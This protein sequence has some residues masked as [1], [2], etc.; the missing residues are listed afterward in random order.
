MYGRI[1]ARE[2]SLF[3]MPYHHPYFKTSRRLLQGSL[4]Q[5]AVS[6]YQDIQEEEMRVLVRN[7]VASPEDFVAHFRRYVPS[8][9]ISGPNL[10]FN[11]SSNA[12]A[13]ILKIAYGWTVT[14]T[15]DKFVAVM[16]EGFRISFE[17]ARPGKWLVDTF[18]IRKYHTYYKF[19]PSY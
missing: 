6:T 10:N 1:M 3:H 7:L 16:V 15:D 19:P 18:P 12:G 9:R 11:L 5:R 14:G 2:V 13:V 8:M 4:N 17:A